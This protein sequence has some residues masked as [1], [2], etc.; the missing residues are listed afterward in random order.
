MH[1]VYREKV[2]EVQCVT[3]SQAAM[4]YKRREEKGER[5]ET[6]KKY[7]SISMYNELAPLHVRDSI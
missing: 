7:H 3:E 4:R 2:L 5:T 6:F 1:V